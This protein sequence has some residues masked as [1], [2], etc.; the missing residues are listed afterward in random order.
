MGVYIYFVLTGLKPPDASLDRHG[1]I[2]SVHQGCSPSAHQ[3]V[4]PV[5]RGQQGQGTAASSG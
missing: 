4:Q 3:S 2:S 1:S 5:P